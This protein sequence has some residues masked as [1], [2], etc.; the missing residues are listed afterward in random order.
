MTRIASCGSMKQRG[1][2]VSLSSPPAG[3]GR[4]AR[5]GW[6]RTAS[7]FGMFRTL[8]HLARGRRH[9]PHLAPRPGLPPARRR[10]PRGSP[11]A[12]RPAPHPAA[13]GGGA[14]RQHGLGPRGRKAARAA[15]PRRGAPR[16][17]HA[18]TR[19]AAARRAR[20]PRP[21]DRPRRR[22]RRRDGARGDGSA[23]AAARGG[24]PAGGAPALGRPG[25]AA[26][27]ARGA[28]RG[29][30]RRRGGPAPG[31]RVVRGPHRGRGQ[32]R[33]PPRHELDP[34]DL[35][36]PPRALS[37]DRR[38]PRGPA[39]ALPRGGASDPRGRR[40]RGGGRGRRPRRGAGVAAAGGARVSL[41][42][43][44]PREA[45]IFARLADAV[46]MPVAPMPAV[47]ATDAVAGFDGWL[48]RAPRINRLVLRAS[49][50]ALGTRFHR[51]DRDARAEALRRLATSR[52]PVVVQLVDGLRA[53]AAAAYYGDDGVMRGL[54]YD[55]GERVRRG[56]AA[57]LERAAAGAAAAAP[58][59]GGPLRA[60]PTLAV[61]P[62]P[63][64]QRAPS[65]G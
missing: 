47:A 61:A 50:L 5:Y 9:R 7:W 3:T 49:L 31:L 59:S 65:G 18:R 28:A 1:M 14:R 33:L 23:A 26:R 52:V 35:P 29:R 42:V 13:A 57:R 64:P 55:A 46:A 32:R 56:R 39:A 25:D 54:G 4:E 44:S 15:R 19:L 63:L 16:R 58:S 27:G 48:A 2:W 22:A 11:R 10:R 21:P 60:A 62:S 6:D 24:R 41:A 8:E 30:A 37:P 34:R 45:S 36:G 17:R 40:G 53:S 38:P 12:R 43:L 51:A 20:R